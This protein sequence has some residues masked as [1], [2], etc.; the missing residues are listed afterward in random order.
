M[1][2]D[3]TVFGDGFT[4]DCEIE[5]PFFEHSAGFG[6]E[7]WIQNHEHPLLGFREH[8][9]VGGHVG[10]TL[11]N[12]VQ[13]QLN[14]QV[15]FVAHLY[16]GTGEASR[17]H[18]L[19]GDHSARAH[20][21]HAGFHQAFFGERVTN[22]NGGAFFLDGV[23]EFSRCHR[24][25]A[26]TVTTC[27]RTEVHNRH[28]DAR[29][30]RVEDLVRVSEASRESVHEAVAGIRRVETNL[31]TNGRHAEAVAVA[32][33]ALN[34]AVDEL[35][36]FRVIGCTERER[37]H[38]CNRTGAHCEYVAEDAADTRCR[39]L[40]GFDVGRVVVAFHFEHDRLTVADIDNTSVLARTADHLRAFG[41]QT[42]EPFLGRL[43]RTVFVPHRREDAQLGKCR[44][45]SDNLEDTFILIWLEA[46]SSNQVFGDF[47]IVHGLSPQ[48]G[49]A[50]LLG[51]AGFGGKARR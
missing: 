1:E 49:S 11:G 48:A 39:T 5:V 46:V 37:V 30:R 23:V 29:R 28:A 41:R 34:H 24:R 36:G 14:A 8:H 13:F 45:S 12:A 22:L 51:Q 50:V 35:F 17:T 47:R 18:V 7:L 32:A 27:F 38:R 15:T 19:N 3:E 33:N 20:Q 16:G 44:L 2:D 4:D 21:F 9:L 40:I 6:L 26:N 31:T 43:I 25:T 42:A 10:F